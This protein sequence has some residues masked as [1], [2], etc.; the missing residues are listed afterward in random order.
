[1]DAV[2]RGKVS[3]DDQV[4]LGRGD[5]TLFHQPIARRS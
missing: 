2:D 4:T 1:M 3:L 5:L